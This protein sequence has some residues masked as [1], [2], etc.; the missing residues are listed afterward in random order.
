MDSHCTLTLQKAN[1]KRNAE[2][3][4][5]AQTHVDMVRHQVPFQQLHSLLSTQLF[6]YFSHSPSCFVTQSLFTI[7]KP[8]VHNPIVQIE[9]MGMTQ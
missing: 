5:D 7:F 2:F 4:W 3:G 8:R 6:E 9:K 1:Y